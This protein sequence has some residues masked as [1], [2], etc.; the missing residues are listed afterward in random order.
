MY[1]LQFDCGAMK[2]IVAAQ[3]GV[4][5]DSVFVVWICKTHQ[6]NK[7]ILTHTE[8]SAPL[9]EMTHNRDKNEIYMDVYK[10]TNNMRFEA[11]R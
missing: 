7:A 10:K 1:G 11:T 2:V 3:L 6:N 9:I 5:I 4:R 8:I